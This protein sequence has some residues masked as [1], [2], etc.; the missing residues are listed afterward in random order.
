MTKIFFEV[1]QAISSTK[2]LLIIAFAVVCIFGLSPNAFASW[3]LVSS[4]NNS[5][6]GSDTTIACSIVG[7]NVGDTVLVVA[8]GSG[9]PTITV[10]DGTT[11]FT[12]LTAITTSNS[13]L[14]MRGSY[15]LASAA[16]GTVPYTVTYSVAATSRN[17]EAYAF[18]PSGT[19]SLDQQASDETIASS[20][21]SSGN[22][23]TTGTDELAFGYEA[24]E[25]QTVPSAMQIN[26]TNATASIVSGEN[27]ALWYLATGSTFTG[28]A[29]FT[30]ASSTRNLTAIVS[31]K[32]TAGGGSTIVS[33]RSNDP[34]TG[35]RQVSK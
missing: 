24:N 7:V 9:T 26:G 20:S 14:T 13:G 8:D 25:N 21:G 32:N 22:I 10:S 28:A 2:R 15:L 16:S 23:T 27:S 11:S 4:C 19:P 1:A 29:T 6:G 18:T 31:F 34:R 3:T 5:N 35:S 30:N 33:R 12:G 17:I